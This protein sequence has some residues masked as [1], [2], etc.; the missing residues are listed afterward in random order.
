MTQGKSVESALVEKE[1]LAVLKRYTRLDPYE[2]VGM[3]GIP[4][5]K[6][7][8]ALVALVAEEKVRSVMTPCKNEPE[9][10]VRYKLT[11]QSRVWRLP[12]TQ[13]PVDKQQPKE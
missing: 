11:R 3:T 8:R 1:V 10:H 12:D 5:S 9:G 6:I 13:T 4:L 2:L 7:E